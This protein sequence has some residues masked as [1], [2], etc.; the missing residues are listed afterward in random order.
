MAPCKTMI[1]YEPLGVIGLYGTWNVPLGVTVKPMISAITA[2]NCCF[3][4]PSEMTPHTSN[5]IKKLVENYLD[6]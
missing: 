4:K 2:G 6:T 3:V 5:V 1:V